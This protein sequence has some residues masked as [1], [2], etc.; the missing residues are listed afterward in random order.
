[1]GKNAAFIEGP[2]KRVPVQLLNVFMI[3]LSKDAIRSDRIAVTL[4]QRKVKKYN[5]YVAA[6]SRN[7]TMVQF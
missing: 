1:M 4:T 2:A 3:G 6:N 5:C 7:L